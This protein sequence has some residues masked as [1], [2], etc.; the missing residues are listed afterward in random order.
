MFDIRKAATFVTS[1]LSGGFV[2]SLFVIANNNRPSDVSNVKPIGKSYVFMSSQVTV[3]NEVELLPWRA[4]DPTMT[5]SHLLRKVNSASIIHH[6]GNCVTTH[7]FNQLTYRSCKV[8]KKA[9]K[10]NIDPN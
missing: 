3:I 6:D 10:N 1:D 8:P 4:R 2:S 7:L 5:Q 9:H